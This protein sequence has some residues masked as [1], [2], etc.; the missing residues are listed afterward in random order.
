MR[1][2]IINPRGFRA[3]VRNDTFF[4]AIPRVLQHQ[5]DALFLCPNMQGEAEAEHWVE[6]LGIEAAV[7]LLPRQPRPQMA[8]LFRASQIVVSPST[9]DGTPNTLLE[10]LACGCFP[11]AGDI[12]SIREWITPGENGLLIDPGNA[13]E[14]A[15][16]IL[17]AILNT[18]LRTR[19]RKYNLKM[20]KK[21]AT[22]KVVMKEAEKFYAKITQK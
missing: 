21:N 3:Y 7:E 15:D 18:D 2:T 8:E 16:A 1:P 5:R 12:E 22:Y 10:A 4:K 11:I 13:R 9:H 20:V 19:S 17:N 6:R 14:L